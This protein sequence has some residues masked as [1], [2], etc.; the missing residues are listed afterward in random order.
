MTFAPVV[1]I[2]RDGWGYSKI[3]KGNAI[4]NAHTPNHTYYIKK[5]PT[6]LLEAS[7]NAVGLPAGTQ[8]GSEVGHLTMGAGRIVWQPLEKINRAI[9][10]GHFFT[11]PIL[12][13]AGENCKKNNSAFHIM[14]LFSDQRWENLWETMAASKSEQKSIPV[15][16]A[17]ILLISS[18][19]RKHLLQMSFTPVLF[20][21]FKENIVVSLSE[22]KLK[23]LIPFGFPAANAVKILM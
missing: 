5:Y 3:K 9:H 21:S 11:N 10:S 15:H 18:S 1:L 16:H 14:G 12:L 23:E 4:A 6:T 22:R 17:I 7:G 8:G 2:V 19:M 13:Q 20:V